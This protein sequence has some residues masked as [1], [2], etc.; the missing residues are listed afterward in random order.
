MLKAVADLVCDPD[1]PGGCF[2]IMSLSESASNVMPEPVIKNVTDIYESSSKSM[3][4]FFKNEQ[5]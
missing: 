1:L 3:L 2:F 5:A 4:E